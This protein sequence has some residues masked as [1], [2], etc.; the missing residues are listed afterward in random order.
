MAAYSQQQVQANDELK[1]LI[2]QSF[3]YFPKVREAENNIAIAQDKLAIAE[4]NNPTVDGLAS[5]RFV[6]PKVTIPI[7]SGSEVKDF[8]F[9]PVNNVN[10][11]IDANYLVFDFGKLKANVE[12]AKTELKYAEHNVDYIK[13]SWPTRLLPSIIIL[14]TCKRHGHRRQCNR[15]S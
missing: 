11:E 15:I 12:K 3:S 9:F 2:T 7:Q 6:Q 13:T 1:S 10:A 5:Y 4:I 8:Q 14:F